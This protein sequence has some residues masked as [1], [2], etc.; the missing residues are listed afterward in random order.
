MFFSNVFDS[1]IVNNQWKYDRSLFVIPKA[2]RVSKLLLPMWCSV[3]CKVI[4][5]IFI[6][7]V[8][9]RRCLSSS[10]NKYIH[11]VI[12]PLCH[13]VI[14][15]I[16]GVSLSIA[17]CICICKMVSQGRSFKCHSIGN[18]HTLCR[19]CYLRG[20]LLWWCCLLLHPN[21]LKNWWG[22]PLT[23]VLYGEVCTFG[24]CSYKQ[25]DHRWHPFACMFVFFMCQE[26]DGVSPI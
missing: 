2:G 7:P 5:F 12:S 21:L 14:W 16:L 1:K 11:C 24:V 22:S 18:F 6:L 26:K 17:V 4:V 23:Q 19:W 25:F 20:V 3:L 13:I 8:V 10:L 15:F 9:G